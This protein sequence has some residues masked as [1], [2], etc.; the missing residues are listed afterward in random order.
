MV[1][2]LLVWVGGEG[3]TGVEHS[4]GRWC[5]GIQSKRGGYKDGGLRIECMS[6]GYR[7]MGVAK[8]GKIGVISRANVVMG[9][10]TGIDS[11][12]WQWS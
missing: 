1:S 5:G 9:E 6:R 4:A 11:G 12:W 10:R 7:S 2:D 8:R 3:V